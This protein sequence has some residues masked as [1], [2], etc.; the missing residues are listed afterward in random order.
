[1]GARKPPLL[2]VS[3]LTG[4]IYIT[5]SYTEIGDGRVVSKTK[6]DV[7]ADFEAIAAER[8]NPTQDAYDAAC[9]ALWKHRATVERIGALCDEAKAEGAFAVSV[10]IILAALADDR[11]MTTIPPEPAPDADEIAAYA[12]WV[13][14]ADAWQAELEHRAEARAD[15]EG[16]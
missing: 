4:R 11:R 13:D 15:E 12:A 8:A 3:S 2:F 9:A 14:A 7:T 1:M 5:T 16:R 6:F 10:E